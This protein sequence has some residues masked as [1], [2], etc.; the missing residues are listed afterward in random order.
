MFSVWV[1]MSGSGRVLVHVQRAR[2]G[3]VEP[4]QA[5]HTPIA[6]QDKVEVQ[7]SRLCATQFTGS[8]VLVYQ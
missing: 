7:S 4:V 6:G 3:P 5:L 8:V 1:G 2:G